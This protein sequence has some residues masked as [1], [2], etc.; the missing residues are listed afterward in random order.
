[1]KVFVRTTVVTKKAFEKCF[2]GRV[3]ELGRKAVLGTIKNLLEISWKKYL[4]L[5]S[6]P[7]TS[8]SFSFFATGTVDSK[9]GTTW[10]GSLCRFWHSFSC[11]APIFVFSVL[12]IFLFK[13]KEVFGAT[14]Q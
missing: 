2:D 10:A 4:L 8:D 11:F 1:M 7:E 9:V 3:S 6:S 14:F 12:K 5:S 13:N